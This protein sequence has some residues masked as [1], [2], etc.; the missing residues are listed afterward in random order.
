MLP[1][2]RTFIALR[3]GISAM[4]LA[5]FHIYTFIGSWP[6][7]VLLAWVG[8]VL[9]D[10]WGSDPRMAAVSA[11]YGLRDRR[12]DRDRCRT[13]CLE[14]V[15][16]GR[17]RAAQGRDYRLSDGRRRFAFHVMLATV[18]STGLERFLIGKQVKITASRETLLYRGGVVSS[19]FITAR[20][21]SYSYRTPSREVLASLRGRR[22]GRH[23]MGSEGEAEQSETSSC[24]SGT[25]FPCELASSIVPARGASPPKRNSGFCVTPLRCQPPCA[26]G[27]PYRPPTCGA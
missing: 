1:V 23:M 17:W 26:S 20:S 12:V 4:P 18:P 11:L 24:R 10:K 7:C 19:S 13:V 25:V 9:G 5:R 22:D 3:A 21:L 14:A 15:A 6:W 8:M 2:V 27:I 16:R